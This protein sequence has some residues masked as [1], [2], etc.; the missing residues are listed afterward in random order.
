[1]KPLRPRYARIERRALELL[2]GA[3]ST[4]PPVDVLKIARLAGA[5]VHFE[6]FEDDVSGVLIR[7]EHGN[8]IGVNKAHAPVRRRFTIAHELGHLLLHDGIPIRVD[9][10]FRVNW[11]KGG[12]AQPPDVEEIEA[13]SFAANLLMP[14]TLLMSVKSFDQF[15]L[16]DDSE[17]AR[18]ACVFEVSTQ[19]MTFRLSQLF[20][21]PAFG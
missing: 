14:K 3:D 21:P 10:T 19:A 16:E 18:L 11:R 2:R 9:K 6:P 4:K 17:I 13:N 7:N 8:A 15:D 1:M 20:R 5:T 12:N